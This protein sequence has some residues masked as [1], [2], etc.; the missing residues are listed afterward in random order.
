MKSLFLLVCL[1]T[2]ASLMGC[3]PIPTVTPPMKVKIG[4]GLGLGDLT[5]EPEATREPSSTGIFGER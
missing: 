4:S 1:L 2:L 3:I 5:D